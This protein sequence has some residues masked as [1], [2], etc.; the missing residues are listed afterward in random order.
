MSNAIKGIISKWDIN[1]L[2]I[3][4]YT[5]LHK[6]EVVWLQLPKCYETKVAIRPCSLLGTEPVISVPPCHKL[7]K[8]A[9]DATVSAVRL[10]RDG[11]TFNFDLLT[12]KSNQFISVPRCT[13]DKSLAKICQ[14]ILEISRK[15]KTTTW[16]TDTQMHARTA[17]RTDDPKTYSLH[18]RLPAAEA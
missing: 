17:A 13:S 1:N 18:R 11:V 4:N 6:A 12:P 7:E 10:C 9:L 2:K 14:Q 15:H 8:V 16:I 5:Q 3:P